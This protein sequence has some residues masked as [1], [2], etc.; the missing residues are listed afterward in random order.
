MQWYPFPHPVLPGHLRPLLLGSTHEYTVIEKWDWV[1]QRNFLKISMP[2]TLVQRNDL[3]IPQIKNMN[4]TSNITSKRLKWLSVLLI[5]WT[6]DIL[7]K[8][9]KSA[10]FFHYNIDE[11][12]ATQGAKNNY[13]YNKTKI[14]QQ[15]NIQNIQKLVNMH[16]GKR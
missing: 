11:H 4:S 9:Y 12:A 6:R 2:E 7:S 16:A 8:T 3:R 10:P 13:K 14:N 1:R 5:S 15:Q